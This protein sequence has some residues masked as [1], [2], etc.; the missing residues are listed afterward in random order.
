MGVSKLPRLGVPQLCG[1]ITSCVDLR[2]GRGLNRSCSPCQELFNDM[3]HATCTQGDWVDSW[4]PV[5]GNQIANL[6]PG[7]SFGH[8]LC[9]KCPNGSCE[10]ILDIYTSVTFQWYKELFK[11]R[12]FDLCNRS[13]KFWESTGTPTPKMGVHLGVWMFIFTLSHTPGLFSWLGVLW[14]LAL[15]ASPRLGLRH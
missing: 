8:N 15:V 3:S 4:L 11:E 14:T 6:I 1:I 2:S 10:L 7:L 13:L 12:G 9:C 5:V